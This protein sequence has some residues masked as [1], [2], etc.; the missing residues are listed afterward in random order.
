[1][2]GSIWR[3]TTVPNAFGYQLSTSHQ[4]GARAGIQT[5]VGLI[6]YLWKHNTK[7]NIQMPCCDGC[8]REHIPGFYVAC[9][10]WEAN[11][12]CISGWGWMTR[13][14]KRRNAGQGFLVCLVFFH[15]F[16]FHYP[17]WQWLG[18]ASPDRSRAVFVNSNWVKRCF[19]SELSSFLSLQKGQLWFKVWPL[20]LG[21]P[22][23]YKVTQLL[24][25]TKIHLLWTF[26]TIST[27]VL[28][29]YQT[30]CPLKENQTWSW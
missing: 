26:I 19:V 17:F 5:S 27:R 15:P 14:R 24:I 7:S 16:L 8:R 4:D 13:A 3:E 22:R 6:L 1:M 2:N 29:F 12:R 28:H 20:C 23:L 30:F 18:S 21:A 9:S 25:T 10:S 11:S